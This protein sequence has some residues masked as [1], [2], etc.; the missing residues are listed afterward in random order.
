MLHTSRRSE[1]TCGTEAQQLKRTVW[2][3]LSTVNRLLERARTTDDTTNTNTYSIVSSPP[4][5]LYPALSSIADNNLMFG[6]SSGDSTSSNSCL[7]YLV[8][9]AGKC[10]HTSYIVSC[11]SLPVTVRIACSKC[12][13]AVCTAC[14]IYCIS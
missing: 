14:F 8:H 12:V 10:T 9:L 7:Q 6:S 13:I 1:D 11:L 4:V 5:E 2:H 3:T